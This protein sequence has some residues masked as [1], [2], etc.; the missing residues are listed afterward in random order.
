MI[1]GYGDGGRGDAGSLFGLL[2]GWRVHRVVVGGRLGRVIA[3]QGW[4]DEDGK[5]GRMDGTLTE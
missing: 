5:E 2:V 3:D 4:I 1:G